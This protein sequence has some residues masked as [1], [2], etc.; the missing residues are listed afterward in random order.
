VVDYKTSP[1]EGADL[2]AFLGREQERYA[3]QMQRYVDALGGDA[4]RGLYFP[5]LAGWRDW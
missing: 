3:E 5:L 1:H 4:H 2:E